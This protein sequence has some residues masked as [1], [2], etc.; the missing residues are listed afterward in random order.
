MRQA[1]G[2]RA[3]CQDQPA[4]R[5]AH[6]NKK[7][8]PTREATS[9]DQRLTND[10]TQPNKNKRRQTRSNATLIIRFYRLFR[11]GRT[12]HNGLVGGSSPPGPTNPFVLILTLHQFSL[13]STNHR[14]RFGQFRR[15]SSMSTSFKISALTRSR[16]CYRKPA[17]SKPIFVSP[18]SISTR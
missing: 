14:M 2:S 1:H 8:C 6:R 11:G 9:P 15:S 10:T 4:N 13:F 12:A 3:T 18:T 5:R 16:H 17:N 7:Q